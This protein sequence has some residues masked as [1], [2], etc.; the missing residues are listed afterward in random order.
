MLV[1][2]K[3]VHKIC[4]VY[5]NETMSTI[6]KSKNFHKRS[7]QKALVV[8]AIAKKHQVTEAMVYMAIRADRGSELSEVIR[9]D[10][11]EKMKSI[12]NALK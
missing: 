10:F 11:N 5:N 7:T 1:Y 2:V 4:A 3:L 9:K 6:D 8:K 12:E